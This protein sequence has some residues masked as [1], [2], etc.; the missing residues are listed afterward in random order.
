[1][2]DMICYVYELAR[3]M[4]DWNWYSVQVTVIKTEE[5]PSWVKLRWRMNKKCIGDGPPAQ[6]FQSFTNLHRNL[7]HF[8]ANY[9]GENNK[10]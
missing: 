3:A 6:L 8:L 5:P 10:D 2:V 7:L 1:M 9:K 4:I